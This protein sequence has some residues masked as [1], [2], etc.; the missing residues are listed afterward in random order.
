M[1]PA[2]VFLGMQDLHPQKSS[3]HCWEKPIL[4]IA[5]T[6][7]AFLFVKQTRSRELVVFWRGLPGTLRKTAILSGHSPT[8][9]FCSFSNRWTGCIQNAKGAM[10][11]TVSSQC[12]RTIC[13][14]SPESAISRC[15]RRQSLL[16]LLCF[17]GSIICSVILSPWMFV[18]LSF[19]QSMYRT[20]PYQQ[21]SSTPHDAPSIAGRQSRAGDQL[22][23]V[24]GAL[25][26]RT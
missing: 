14:T 1:Y 15:L 7:A 20:C 17:S 21:R 2:S 19:D 11:L 10:F 8:R 5:S 4:P 25:G 26:N 24:S 12:R 13:S 23:P 9:C 6:K 16:H 22:R 3:V 18:L